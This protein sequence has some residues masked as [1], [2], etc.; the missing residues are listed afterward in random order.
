MKGLLAKKITHLALLLL[1]FLGSSS[2]NSAPSSGEAQSVPE[3]RNPGP[4]I[5]TGDIGAIGG[6]EQFGSD[7]TQVGLGVSTT[8]CNAGDVI[9]RF[10]AMPDTHHPII[11]HNLYRMSGGPGND[12]RFEQIGQSWVKHAYGSSNDNECGFGCIPSNFSHLGVGCSDT[13]A[14]FQNAEQIALGSRALVNPFT[15]VFLATAVNH[16]NHTHTETSHRIL[17]EGSDLNTTLNPGA[18][19]YAEVQYISSDEYEWCQAHPTQCNMYNNASYR[20]FSVSGT[21]SFTFSE[22]GFTMQTA[23]INAWPGAVINPVEPE[24]GIDGRA[25]LACKVTGPVG[26]VWHYEY[27]LYNE[28]LDRAIQSFSVPLGCGT[29][30][31]NL[32][33]HAPLNHPGFPND[34]TLGDA[35]FSNAA[36]SSTQSASEVSW[37]TETFAQNQNANAIRW[38]TLYNFRFDS[39]KPPLTTNATIG[40][41]K[42]G[43]P[44]TVNVLGPN[45]CDVTPTPSPTATPTPATPTPTATPCTGTVFTE[46]FDQVTAPALPPGWS[47]DVNWVTSTTAPHTGPN[48]AFVDDPGFTSDRFLDSPNLTISSAAAQISFRNYFNLEPGYDGGVLEISSPNINGG[49]FTDVTDPA[50]GGSFV[51]GGY[52]RT[53]D[54]STFSPIAGRQAWSG[55]SGG[56]LNTVVRLGP[57]VDGQTIRLRFRMASDVFKPDVGW[58]IDTVTSAGVCLGPLSTPTP[59]PPPTPTPTPTPAQALNLST[60]MRVQ[61]G[62]NVGIGGFII[63]GT[64]PKHLLLRAIGPSLA[65]SGIP[66]VLADPVMELHGPD[67]FV[68]IT[69]DNWRD[70]PAQ[71]AAIIATG[72]PPNDNLE[73]AIDS[74]LDPGAYTAIVRGQDNTSGVGLV[75]L[76]D[77][78]QAVP[79]K[80][81]NIST[82][83]FVGTGSDIMIAGFILGGHSGATRIVV[84][85]LGPSLT[86]TGVLGALPD[87]TL[88]LRDSNG[89]LLMSNNDWQDDPAQANLLNTAGLAPTNSLESGIAVTLLPGLYTALLGGLNNATGVGL[90]EVYDLGTP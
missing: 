42:T 38:G 34:G 67:G 43:T 59:T 66:D 20:R 75:E 25:Y 35:G 21:T 1:L 6:L 73:S 83:A 41:F 22:I 11:P 44:V 17:V 69:N 40:F 4:D 8:A 15:G 57:N 31:T 89:A 33:F 7:G 79:A 18:T 19:Y 30:V 62:D 84:R 80:L 54:P 16:T 68:T 46:N 28:N 48:D 32:G 23:A 52:N 72:I 85:G 24:P 12:E 53:I 9:V 47:G 10:I 55:N 63:T 13:Y 86:S 70:D 90:I 29:T 82:R 61:T 2:G 71:E 76:Y 51:S 50:A 26:G 88:Q 3:G 14:N 58:R 65:Q 45:F 49:A 36:W 81:A 60:R 5:I 39:P 77:L 78:S 56:Y 87:P 74:T 27:A 37:N 64:A